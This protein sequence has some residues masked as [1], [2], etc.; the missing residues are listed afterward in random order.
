MGKHQNK[1]LL[2]TIGN[3]DHASSRVR[4][5]Q[6]TPLIKSEL[7]FKVK[8]IPRV[9]TKSNSLF[10][11]RVLN[12]LLKRIYTINRF[13]HVLF[14]SYDVIFIQ[15]IFISGWIMRILARRATKIIFDFDDAIYLP[16]EEYSR[17]RIRTSA[18]I[19]NA[20]KVIVSTDFLVPFCEKHNIFPTVINS[21]VDAKRI[22]PIQKSE[23]G[24]RIGWI[25]SAWTT[26]FLKI[27]Q[28]PLAQLSNEFD[29]ELYVV[30]AKPGFVMDGVNLRKSA[31][32][33]NQEA[34]QLAS[35]NIGIMPLP[36]SSYAEGKGGYKLLMY[37]SAGLPVIASPVGIN[38]TIVEHG[39]NGFLA[40]TEEDW[41]LALKTLVDDKNKRMQMGAINR[42]ILIEKY[43]L[44]FCFTLLKDCIR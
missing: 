7:N 38:K 15:K 8:W 17:N 43:S 27:I 22:V 19:E 23:S 40:S 33:L 18:M 41:Y 11:K 21:G 26:D 20:D 35:M 24:I 4:A 9:S 16:D 44:E 6:Y 13:I 32:S 10:K 12:P 29:I 5:L 2:L 31:W 37:M 42:Q 14:G 30:G 34:E 39:K 1:M 25:G 36:E 3:E 28:K